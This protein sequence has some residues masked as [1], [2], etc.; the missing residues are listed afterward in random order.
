M[1]IVILVIQAMIIKNKWTAKILTLLL[2]Y[3]IIKTIIIGITKLLLTMMII[4][5]IIKIN[6]SNL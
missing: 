6:N 1:I 2:T 5:V 3:V 4:I